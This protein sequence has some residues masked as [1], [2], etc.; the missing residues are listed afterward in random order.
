MKEMS[1]SK[2]GNFDVEN[3]TTKFH[4]INCCLELSDRL[5]IKVLNIYTGYWSFIYSQARA[6]I[7]PTRLMG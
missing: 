2:A 1:V 5:L 6:V 4:Y 3:H 7:R